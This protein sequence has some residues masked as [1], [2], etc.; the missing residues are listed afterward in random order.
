MLWDI[1]FDIN[2][3]I[4]HNADSYC[5]QITGVFIIYLNVCVSIQLFVYSVSLRVI[6]NKSTS[7]SHYMCKIFSELDALI[8]KPH[9]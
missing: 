1:Y 3:L 2:E 7:K 5:V 6:L 8:Y 4:Q 9:N